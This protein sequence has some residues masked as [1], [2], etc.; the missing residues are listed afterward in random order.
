MGLL[1][2][3]PPSLRRKLALPETPV[4]ANIFTTDPAIWYPALEPVLSRLAFRVQAWQLGSDD[5]NSFVGYAQLNEKITV[6]K[7]YLDRICQNVNLTLGW[8][9][10]DQEPVAKHAPWRFLSMSADPSLTSQELATYLRAGA[11]RTVG[12]WVHLRPLDRDEFDTATRAA[13]LVLRMTEAKAQGAAAIFLP[14]PF[15]DRR[16]VMNEDGTPGELLL[17]WRTAAVTLSG[18]LLT[19]LGNLVLP[20]GSQ[21]RLFGRGDEAVLVVWS[22]HAAP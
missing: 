2:N 20:A 3:P 22:D 7:K 5:D 16:G 8:G 4:A 21:N 14:E 17:P 1:H 15:D 13:D 18:Q 9:W 12:H 19:Y 6:V 11:S 10:L